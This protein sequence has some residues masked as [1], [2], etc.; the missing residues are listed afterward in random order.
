MSSS[1]ETIEAYRSMYGKL[2]SVKGGDGLSKLFVGGGHKHA[3]PLVTRTPRTI[4]AGAYRDLE[5][6][7]AIVSSFDPAFLKF[8]R[9]F[10]DECA[11]TFEPKL[12]EQNFSSNGVHSTPDGLR[13]V[14]GYL[15]NPMSAVAVDNAIYRAS[16]GLSPGYSKEEQTI[17]DE[18][19]RIVFEEWDPGPI[20]LPKISTAGVRRFTY[21]SV[22]KADYAAMLF[23]P[24]V[25]EDVLTRIGKND[26]IG[27]LDEYEMAFMLYMQTR[28]QAESPEK[29]RL[30][31]NMEYALSGGRKAGP[32][33]YADKRVVLHG[34]EYPDFGGMRARNVQAGPWTVNCSQQIIA[35]GHMRALFR[36]FPD[37]FHVTTP[38]QLESLLNGHH[39][40]CGD[41]TEY[42]RSMSHDAIDTPFRIAAEYWDARYVKM[43]ATL[44][45]APYYSR[46]LE[47]GG[48]RGLFVGDPRD[49]I[50][51]AVNCGNRSGHAW[52]SLIAKG[53]KVVD[54]LIR[55]HHLGHPVI[56][57][58]LSWLR[59][60]QMIK[61][62]NNGDDMV[63][64]STSETA[65]DHVRKAFAD[66]KKGHYLV[67][68]EV[69]QVYSGYM[70]I[71]E[72]ADSLT[73]KARARLYS[74]VEKFTVPERSAGSTHRQFWPVGMLT[75]INRLD[76]NENPGNGE[77]WDI[78]TRCW[79]KNLGA[80]HGELISLIMA[81]VET[82]PLDFA[83][84]S[85]ADSEVLDDPEKIHYKWL[86]EELSEDVR[87]AI[88]SQITYGEY[89]HLV[90]T[91]YGGAVVENQYVH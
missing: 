30:I 19:W 50:K 29:K 17:A 34:Q 5:E 62:L 10:V 36:R 6:P 7:E 11:R 89:A 20:N 47:L 24:A 68:E 64:Y 46:P 57:N 75:R 66:P 52:T 32:E 43:G 37:V 78:V 82:M 22:W 76:P 80:T 18:F 91:Y 13:C 54:D 3:M 2:P 61:I 27:L 40:V 15:M 51:Y 12:D 59:G 8:Q 85:R 45:H 33:L 9:D 48:E 39:V 42:D 74:G 4:V 83:G 16:L 58:V 63:N 87:N 21:D 55:F 35:S 41:V 14:A 26:W 67:K 88:T 79:S 71:R 84:R 69:G 25:F 31:L 60:E 1:E 53:N 23:D 49:P 38:E 70:L 73:Y 44:M 56:G 77:L 81:A 72:S 28:A 90:N 86:P 65:I